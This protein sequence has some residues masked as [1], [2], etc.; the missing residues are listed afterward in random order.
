M[1][2]EK[3]QADRKNSGK[4]RLALIDAYFQEELAKVLS[5]GAIKYDSDNWRIGLPWT[6]VLDSLE[7]HVM[8]FKSLDYSDE[9]E[10]SKL[11]HMAHVACN[12]MFLVWYSKFRKEFDDRYKLKAAQE[13]QTTPSS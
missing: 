12:A 9:D 2:E 1:P 11:H 8:Q 4:P 6:E 3:K 5:M 7:R 13:A 10:E